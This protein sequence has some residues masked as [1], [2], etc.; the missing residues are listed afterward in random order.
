MATKTTR[1]G[2]NKA[3]LQDL[4]RDI[5]LTLYGENWDIIDT[6]AEQE[7]LEDHI[8]NDGIHVAKDGA[9]QVGLNAEMV[10]GSRAEDFAPAGHDHDA[11]YYPRPEADALFA[12]KSATYSK[13]ECDNLFATKTSVYTKTEADALFAAKADVYTKTEAD[14]RYPSRT[15][16]YLRTEAEDTFA[17]K[18]D[19][20]T[21]TEADGLFALQGD[22]YTKAEADARYPLATDVYTQAE[23][24]ARYVQLAQYNVHQ[25][26]RRIAFP[27]NNLDFYWLMEVTQTGAPQ[28]SVAASAYSG[29][30]NMAAGID[31]RALCR[32]AARLY[33]ACFVFSFAD[34]TFSADGHIRLL[35]HYSSAD[36]YYYLDLNPFTNAVRVVQV[37]SGAETE[38]AT[39][40]SP[41][42]LVAR[43]TDQAGELGNPPDFGPLYIMA[44]DVAGITASVRYGSVNTALY[45]AASLLEVTTHPVEEAVSRCGWAVTGVPGLNIHH[46][47]L[48]I[49]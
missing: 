18:T 37:N 3:E 42:A 44:V 6:L 39:L 49:K 9:L 20:Y 28:W 8:Y 41:P 48:D 40:T 17:A 24:D 23:A 7:E 30:T 47:V 21:K 22:C 1:L 33:G 26:Q 13:T 5:H 19:V 27:F 31:L 10:G 38:L 46:F 12:L 11:T 4:I 2:L 32:D 36:T 35:Y 25:H 14:S 29:L 16:V 15:E 34:V 45:D 43:T